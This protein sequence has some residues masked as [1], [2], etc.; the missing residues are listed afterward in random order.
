MLKIENTIKINV[1]NRYKET[2]TNAGLVF[3][4]K[5]LTID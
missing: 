5:N 2:Y 4:N 1:K 3:I